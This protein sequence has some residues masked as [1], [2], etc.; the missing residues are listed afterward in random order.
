MHAGH[1]PPTSIAMASYAC[2]AQPEL[3]SLLVSQGFL[4]NVIR[5]IDFQY[6]RFPGMDL[7]FLK[8]STPSHIAF[9]LLHMLCMFVVAMSH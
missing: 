4:G 6:C 3:V 8:M 1:L 2:L 9:L 5:L 7:P